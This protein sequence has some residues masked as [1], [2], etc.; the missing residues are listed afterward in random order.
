[1]PSQLSLSFS[2]SQ[3]Q[4]DLSYE[5]PSFLSYTSIDHLEK[6]KHELWKGTCFEC[7]L[8]GPKESYI[9]WNFD[10]FG[11]WQS[12]FFTSYRNPNP[13]QQSNH[14]PLSYQVNEGKINFSLPMTKEMKS[15]N[16][17]VILEGRHF[18]AFK[19]PATGADFHKSEFFYP[20]SM[21][22]PI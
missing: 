10:L 7:F 13:P 3:N 14:A 1:M 4:I 22:R 2:I 17:T 21:P 6:R 16:P 15:I 11:N 5:I 19:H 20:I 18:Y 8:M 9:E 12:Y